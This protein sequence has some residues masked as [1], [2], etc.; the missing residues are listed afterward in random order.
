MNKKLSVIIPVYNTEKYVRQ[1]V[2][3]VLQQ[4]YTPIEVILVNDGSIDNSLSIIKKFESENVIVIN[5]KNGG[6]V[7]ARNAGIKIATGEY[8]AFVDSDDYIDP[9]MY[10][11]LICQMEQDKTE[12]IFMSPNSV[13][14]AKVKNGVITR[15]EALVELANLRLPVS[16]CG[17]VF[18]TK[19]IKEVKVPSDIHFFEDFLFVY[20]ALLQVENI[21]LADVNYYHYVD[22]SESINKQGINDKRMSCLKIIPLVEIGGKLYLNEI[23]RQIY[24]AISHFI[25]CNIL[26]L[27]KNV[28]DN[29]KY[30][31]ILKAECKRNFREIIKQKTVPVSYKFINCYLY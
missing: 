16:V 8:I 28:K 9:T 27:D 21:S 2:E 25:I 18:C 12:M 14:A 24:F 15:N 20:I 13:K 17:G 23:G 19:Y 7:S 10:E 6:V 3:S 5:K 4:T 31:Q 1:C 30:E 26:F 29:Q 22:N 11:K